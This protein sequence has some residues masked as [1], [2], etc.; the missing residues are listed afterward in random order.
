[1]DIPEYQKGE[2]NKFLQDEAVINSGKYSN[3]LQSIDTFII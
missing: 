1:M 3:I 2:F